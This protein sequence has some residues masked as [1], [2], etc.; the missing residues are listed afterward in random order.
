MVGFGKVSRVR[1][2]V[3]AIVMVKVRVIFI[4]ES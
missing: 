4:A 2:K 1:V 3:R